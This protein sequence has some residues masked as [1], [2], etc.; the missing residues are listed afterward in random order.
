[1]TV[2]VSVSELNIVS[3][4][5]SLAI[6]LFFSGMFRASVHLTCPDFDMSIAGDPSLTPRE[7]RCSAAV[8]MMV[9]LHKKAK[10]DT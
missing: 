7:A 1:L 10:H 6:F 5:V 2:I 4:Q 9:E 8:N 3:E